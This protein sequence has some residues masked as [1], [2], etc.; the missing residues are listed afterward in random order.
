MQVFISMPM[1]GLDESEIVARRDKIFA[2]IDSLSHGKVEL[3][4]SILHF[5]GK[6]SVYYLAKS[7]ELLSEADLVVFDTG[8]E[9]ARGCQIEHLVCEEYDIPYVHYSDFDL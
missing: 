9:H 2:E 7:M 8:W 1:N 6:N 5:E 4:D 3:I